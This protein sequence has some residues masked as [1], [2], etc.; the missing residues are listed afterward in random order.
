MSCLCLSLPSL[1]AEHWQDVRDFGAVPDGK[2]LCTQAIQQAIDACVAEGGGTVHLPPGTWLSGTIHMKSHVTLS[3]GAGC[4]LLGSTNQEDYPPYKPALRSRTSNYACQSLIAGED[5]EDIAIVGH[6][7]INGN[8]SAFLWKGLPNRPYVI[9]FVNCRDIQ[10]ENISMRD[11]PMWMQHYLAC[12]RVRISGITV[13]NHATWNNDGMDIDACHDVV[14]SNCLLDTDDDGICFKSTLD[15]A[16]ENITVAN[17]VISSHCN[18]IKMGTETNGGFRNIG[19]SNCSILSPRFTQNKFGQQRGLAA[20]ALEIVD[21]GDMDRIAISNISIQGMNTPIFLRLGDRGR[22]VQEGMPKPPVGKL[23]NVSLSNIV[24]TGTSY[25]GCSITGLPDHPIENVSLSDISLGFEGGGTAEH[26]DREVQEQPERYPECDMFGVLPAYGFYCRHVKGLRF[27][28]VRLHAEQP[29][30]R[31]ALVLDD[32]TSTVIDGLSP[33]CEPDAI[34]A[35]RLIQVDGAMVSGCQFLSP[36]MSFLQAEGSA[37]QN[38]W[39][40]GN[41]VPRAAKKFVTTPEVPPDAV[42]QANNRLSAEP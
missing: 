28:N 41:Q 20:I 19:I 34:A 29:D 33:D 27:R 18:A 30:H 31:P 14:V 2:T 35:I 8:G 12:D 40:T 36:V 9:R 4:T 24:A 10:V 5:L 25:T 13:W 38:V 21:G 3:L 6:G 11:S 23:R 32:V 37:T 1:G 17:C 26:A 16:C 39:L 42:Q 15:R 7:T 22:P